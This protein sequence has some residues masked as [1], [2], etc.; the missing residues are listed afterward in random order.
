MTFARCDS[1]PQSFSLLP[2]GMRVNGPPEAIWHPLIRKNHGCTHFVVGRDHAGPGNEIDGK[3]FYGPY[4]AQEIF[5]KYET[6]IGVTMVPFNMMVYLQDQDKYVPDNCST[7]GIACPKHF[8]HGIAPLL[9]RRRGDS[10]LVHVSRSGPGI[11]TQLPTTTQAR[12]YR[13]FHRTLRFRQPPLPTCCSRSSWKQE[14][15]L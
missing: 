2:L 5:K 9:E 1:L 7:Q 10:M 6:D 15:V 14:D 3:P 12:N 8:G 11:A 13:V 4:R